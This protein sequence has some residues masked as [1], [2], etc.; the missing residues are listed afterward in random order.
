MKDLSKAKFKECFE[1]LH[2]L[3][4][5]QDIIFQNEILSEIHSAIHSEIHSG[6]HSGIH[7]KIHSQRNYEIYSEIQSQIQSKIQS[8]IQSQLQSQFSY[9][10]LVLFDQS[11]QVSVISVFC[12]VFEC[13]V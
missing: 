5:T 11:I 10:V 2:C 6:K 4:W 12:L 13:F 8:Q 1:I 7:C 3:L 9:S